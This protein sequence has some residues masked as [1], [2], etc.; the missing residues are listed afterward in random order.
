MNNYESLEKFKLTEKLE[1][2]LTIKIDDVCS[3]CVICD[4][5]VFVNF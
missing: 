5:V 1:A 4:E 3:F 2:G